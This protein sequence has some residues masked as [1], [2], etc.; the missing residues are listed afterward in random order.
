MGMI[1]FVPKLKIS[2]QEPP[3]KKI[4]IMKP[5]AQFFVTEA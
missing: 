4:E 5:G 1:Q 2:S 3:L